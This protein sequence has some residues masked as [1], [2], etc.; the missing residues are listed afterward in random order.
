MDFSF[1][2][3]LFNDN[4]SQ[5]SAVGIA[6]G[7]GLESRRVG[8]K[9]PVRA[10]FFSSLRR[11][12]LFCGPPSL[13]FDAYRG[14]F[15]RG[16]SDR[17]MKL[18]T[19]LQLVPRSRIRGSIHPLPHTSSCRSAELVKHKNFTFFPLS[20]DNVYIPPFWR[21]HQK[22]L[23]CGYRGLCKN[24][25]RISP[26]SVVGSSVWV[27]CCW[28][29]SWCSHWTPMGEE[30]ETVEIVPTRRDPTGEPTDESSPLMY[31]MGCC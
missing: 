17:C 21:R 6:T 13:L 20:K 1:S 27:P 30:A 11:P 26:E 14:L 22:S 9:V 25:P 5:D 10:K 24:W 15:P 4:G 29:D 16:L 8:V 12:D 31:S 2:G 7:Y 28:S 19:H 23:R 3:G 18:T